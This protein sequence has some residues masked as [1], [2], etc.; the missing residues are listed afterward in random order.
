[1]THNE[2]W[3]YA[4]I[5]HSWGKHAPGRTNEADAVATAHHLLLSHGWAAEAI[6]SAA[7][8]AQV[9]IAL[10]L[11]HTYPASDSPEDEAAAWRV[12]GAG[13]RWFLDPIFR[14]SYPADLLDRSELVAPFVLDGDME[15]IAAPIDFLGV[16]NYFR[17][18]VT[19]ADEG[20]LLVNPPGSPVTDMGWEVYPDGLRRLLV[21]LQQEYEP[22]AIYI[23]ENG[24]AFGDVRVHDGRVHDP[25]RTSYLET[26]IDA[27]VERGRGGRAR[28]R[29]LRLEPARQL[30]VGRGVL[31]ALRDR[32]R[33]LSRRSSACPRTASTGT[34]TSSRACAGRRGL[35]RSRRVDVKAAAVGLALS[36]RSPSRARRAARAPTA[37]RCGRSSPTAPTVE[38]VNAWSLAA[39]PGGVWWVTNESTDTSTLYDADGRKQLLTVKVDGGPTGIVYS[40]GDGFLVRGG[41]RTAPARFIFACEDGMIRAWAPTVPRGWSTRAQVAVDSGASGALF[42]GLAL[43]HGRLY[44]TDFHNDRVLMFDS[45]WRPVR[46]PGAFRDSGI[47]AWYA[48]FGIA[49]FGDRVFVTY[50]YPAPVNGNDAPSGG[51]VDEFDLDGRL[52]A[53]VGHTSELDQP[54]GLALAPEGFGRLGGDLLVANFGSERINVYATQGQ[55]LGVPRPASRSRSPASGG[56]PSGR[57]APAASRRRSFTQPARTA[58]MAQPRSTSAASLARSV[59]V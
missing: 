55:R 3:V 59:R 40:G 20:P 44:V 5:G 16:N 9:G 12:D 48:P 32:L 13:N 50:A 51:Y 7:P 56:S 58:G 39:A 26:H 14:G 33:R 52:V 4:W 46:R 24:A 31:E 28:P 30:R 53:H 19:A 6:R 35:R 47:P 57:G 15:A 34:A 10:N 49:A 17:F 36:P 27:V 41:G 38:L 29:L 43:A 8:D 25:E 37:S 18:V 42:R 2:P 23:T 22:P 21:R 11:A 54:W 1:M 45:R